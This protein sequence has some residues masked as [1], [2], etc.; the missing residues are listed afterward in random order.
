M[1]FNT[2][3]SRYSLCLVILLVRPC[4][5]HSAIKIDSGGLWERKQL[6]YESTVEGSNAFSFN[7]SSSHPGILTKSGFGTNKSAFDPTRFPE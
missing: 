2:K 6:K 7:A 5:S 4:A 1:I 3:I